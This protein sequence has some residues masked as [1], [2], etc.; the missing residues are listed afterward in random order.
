M[1]GIPDG[2]GAYDNRDGSFTLL[3]NHE[4]GSDKGVVRARWSDRRVCVGLD[5]P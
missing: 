4:L 1:V 3:M 2:L 5:Y